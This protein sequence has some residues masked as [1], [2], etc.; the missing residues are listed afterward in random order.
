MK[1]VSFE[2][3]KVGQRFVRRTYQGKRKYTYDE[4]EKTSSTRAR[5]IGSGD[6]FSLYS[7]DV[8]YWEEDD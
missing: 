6:E 8:C 4:Y 7:W 1:A 2:S 3:L 5:K